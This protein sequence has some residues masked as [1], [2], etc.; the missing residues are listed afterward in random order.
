MSS[1]SSSVDVIEGEALQREDG[2]DRG[3]EIALGLPA[4][5]IKQAGDAQPPEARPNLLGRCGHQED[6]AVS[7]QFGQHAPGPDDEVSADHGV[8]GNADDQLRNGVAHHRLDQ[9][10]LAADEKLPG[11]LADRRGIAE[12]QPK[13]AALGLVGE[14][15]AEQLDHDRIAD[16]RSRL[17]RGVGRTR[18]AAGRNRDA[19]DVQPRLRL[20]LVKQLQSLCAARSRPAN[21]CGAA[22][23]AARRARRRP[24]S[25]RSRRRCR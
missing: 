14:L 5:T 8:A 7:D 4:M 12:S 1:S 20:R 2:V 17:D 16:C 9:E 6:D 3:L 25:P 10:R 18:D 13:R 11:G 21:R 19:V 23:R 15:L 24:R 22:R